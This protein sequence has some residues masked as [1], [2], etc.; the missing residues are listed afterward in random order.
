LDLNQ[1]HQLI[2]IK[3]IMRLISGL[4]AIRT[5]T[6]KAKIGTGDEMRT[7]SP[8]SDATDLLLGA[9]GSPGEEAAPWL[10]GGKHIFG[11]VA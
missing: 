6:R 9:I 2:L 5:R 3:I 1:E 7:I 10:I 11:V 4:I 8:R